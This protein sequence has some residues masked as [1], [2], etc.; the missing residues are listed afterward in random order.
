MVEVVD[1]MHTVRFAITLICLLL[2]TSGRSEADD[3]PNTR[4]SLQGVRSMSVGVGVTTSG[5]RDMRP[6]ESQIRTDVELRLR[7]N[8]VAVDHDSDARIYVRVVLK[9]VCFRDSQSLGYAYMADVE[10]DQTVVLPRGGPVR[11]D[12]WSTGSL[13][14]T[15]EDMTNTVRVTIRDHLDQF[16]N[17]YLAANPKPR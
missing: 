13:G 11:A 15:G 6:L 3:T 4:R 12:T 9:P 5:D 2:A 7:Q 10:F 16:L 14:V 8:S 1:A 17:A